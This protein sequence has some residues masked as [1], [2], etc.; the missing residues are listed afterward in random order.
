[1]ADE[2]SCFWPGT[3]GAPWSVVAKLVG[4]LGFA[5]IALGTLAGVGT[6][7]DKGGALILQNL[8]KQG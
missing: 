1:M 6:L 4:D 7:L 8:V 2:G 3:T 5:P